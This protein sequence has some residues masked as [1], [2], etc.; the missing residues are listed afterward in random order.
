[1]LKNLCYIRSF[2]IGKFRQLS[3][4]PKSIFEIVWVYILILSL[5]LTSCQKPEAKRGTQE[6][7]I[8]FAYTPF[9][10]DPRM[11]TEPVT[12]ALNFMLY[13]GLTR[14]EPD[15]TTSLALA[16]WIEIS[17]DKKTYLFYLKQSMWS[18]GSPLTAYHFEAAW[19]KALDPEF[20]SNS[21]S[22]LF[23]I[24]N[25]E[26]AKKGE[27]SIGEVGVQAL[28]ERT[29]LVRLSRP[30]P[31]FL[32]L[33]SYCCYFPVPFN[34]D[35]VPPPSKEDILSN[36]PF[37][38]TYWKNE[39][40]I[41]LAKNPYYWDAKEVK[42][43]KI[44]ALIIPD[45]RTAFNLFEKGELDMIGGLTSHIPLDVIPSLKVSG[46]LQH[47][48]I[49]GTTF[50]A[51]NIQR[52]PFNNI[53]IRKAFAYAINRKEI[54]ENLSQ[55]FD[56]VA[57]GLVPPL[58]KESSSLFFADCEKNLARH[59]FEKGLN[60]LG[61]TKKEFPRLTYTFFSSELHEKLAIILQS[62]WR[63][64]L[65][66]EV[67]LQGQEFKCH[68]AALH[69]KNYS[70]AQMSWIGQYYDRMTF[71]ERFTS[72]GALNYSDWENPDYTHL[73]ASSCH[74][75]KKERDALLEQ[76]EEIISDEM[77][78]IPL[79]HFHIV[80][81]KNPQLKNIAISPL[82]DMQFHRAFFEP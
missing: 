71:L 10:A 54:V 42:L 15:G 14:L 46:K 70:F 62:Y 66:V 35:K 60:E 76:A 28:D 3:R 40:E 2:M 36:G 22:L 53:Y 56:D 79:L 64:V 44:H 61:I 52:Y 31:Y 67:D 13:E 9:S 78:I 16:E 12:S 80:Y 50:S 38:L 5:G 73:I 6:L 26:K 30:T 33:T 65:D 11:H 45:E 49:L 25:G 23:P 21:C 51:F 68:L 27:C 77:P 81:S 69:Y 39:N 37:V 4:C 1:M 57:T 19:K 32:E 63:E 74:K 59:F 43:E 55:M 72:K 18:D 8:S 58:L 75:E 17:E 7:R 24:K 41:I 82:G 20:C 48:P 29:L 47:R 34:G